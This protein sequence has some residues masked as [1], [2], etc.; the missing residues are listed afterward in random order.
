MKLIPAHIEDC[1]YCHFR[2][3]NEAYCHHYKRS[4]IPEGEAEEPEGPGY[5]FPEFCEFPD[6]PEEGASPCPE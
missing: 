3:D 4:T 5:W 2:D 1:S 6:V